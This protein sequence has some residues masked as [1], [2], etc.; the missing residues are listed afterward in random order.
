MHKY[1][2][3]ENNKEKIGSM[4]AVLIFLIINII[5]LFFKKFNIPYYIEEGWFSKFFVASST[6]YYL[7]YEQWFCKKLWKESLFQRFLSTPNLNGIWDMKGESVNTLKGIFLFEGEIK[8]IQEFN[9]IS[10]CLTTKNSYSSSISAQL[11]KNSDGNYK[12]DYTYSNAPN[13]N[14]EMNRDMRKH[15]GHCSIIFSPDL[16]TA[17]CRYFND[18]RERTSYGTMKLT[19]KEEVV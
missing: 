5:N 3:T 15:D 6:I 17:K 14:S 2:N 8:I 11:T 10:I 7:L 4:F 13:D 18:S 12:L 16:K 1:T 9:K 19:K